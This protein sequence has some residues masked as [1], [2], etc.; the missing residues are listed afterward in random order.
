MIKRNAG[1]ARRAE[2]KEIAQQA[3]ATAADK[4][5]VGSGPVTAQS[6]G[7]NDPVTG[8]LV[9]YGILGVTRASEPFRLKD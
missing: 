7:G 5:R 9:M 2:V 3:T 6:V 4:A 1:D 8:E